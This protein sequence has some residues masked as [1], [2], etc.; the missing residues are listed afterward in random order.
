MLRSL[1]Q[2]LRSWWAVD[3]PDERIE[4]GG[5]V[6]LDPAYNSRYTA[7]RALEAYAN[8]DEQSDESPEQQ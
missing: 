6:Y 2:R 8:L 4:G 5:G 7:E 3:D 1:L